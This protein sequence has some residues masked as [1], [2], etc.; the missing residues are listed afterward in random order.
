MPPFAKDK[1]LQGRKILTG[2]EGGAAVIRLHRTI[3]FLHWSVRITQLICS[4]SVYLSRSMWRYDIDSVRSDL[5]RA[6][7]ALFFE[8]VAYHMASC[9][10]TNLIYTNLFPILGIGKKFKCNGKTYLSMSSLTRTFRTFIW[11]LFTH[12]LLPLLRHQV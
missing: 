6:L 7:D 2:Q 8:R 3:R 5:W 11:H 9:L 1:N 4:S 10:R 12:I